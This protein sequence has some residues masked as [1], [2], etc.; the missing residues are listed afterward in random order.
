MGVYNEVMNIPRE[1]WN[2]LR[3]NTVRWLAAT[4]L[5]RMEQGS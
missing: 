4:G 2:P 5:R 3:D 1:A